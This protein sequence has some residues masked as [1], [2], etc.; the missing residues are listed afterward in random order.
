MFFLDAFVDVALILALLP[1]VIVV[2]MLC[3]DACLALMLFLT[4]LACS[5]IC[6]VFTPGWTGLGPRLAARCRGLGVGAGQG[7]RP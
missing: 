1:A 2:S 5:L 7:A 3:L 4:W 6:F